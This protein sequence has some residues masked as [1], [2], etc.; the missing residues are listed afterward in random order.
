MNT[1]DKARELMAKD[2]Q[3]DEH[4][5]ENM[6]E[7]AADIDNAVAEAVEEKARELLTDER[8][9]EQRL[10]ENMLERAVEAIQAE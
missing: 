6:L 5:Q 7:R 8:Q 3:Q 2:R 9:S 1:Q 4:L 10:D